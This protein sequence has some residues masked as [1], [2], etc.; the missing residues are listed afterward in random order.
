MMQLAHLVLLIGLYVALDLATP[1]VPGAFV[2]AGDGSAEARHVDRFRAER[3][4][5][6][7]RP[8]GGAVTLA[9]PTSSSRP[10]SW[11]APLAP[12][13]HPAR[14]QLSPERSAF[15]PDDH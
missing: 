13:N 12:E 7:L 8:V 5:P 1:L 11:A 9:E 2:F 15:S 3:E 6:P 14:S 4:P 10:V